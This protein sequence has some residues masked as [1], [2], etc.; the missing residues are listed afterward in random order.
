MAH[1]Q[2]PPAELEDLLQ[3]H[4]AVL[5]VAVVGMPDDR[6]GELPRAYVVCKPNE[7]VT[8]PEIIK[9]VEGS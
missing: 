6:A 2:V 1:Y 8:P 5:D 7:H 9:F 4:P 3:K